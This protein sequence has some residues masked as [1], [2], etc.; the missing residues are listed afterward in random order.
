VDNRHTLLREKLSEDFLLIPIILSD[1]SGI[2]TL[3]VCKKEKPA[4]TSESGLLKV[5]HSEGKVREN[6][7][8]K[9]LTLW[10]GGGM[11]PIYGA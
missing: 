5:V 7:S 10:G 6:G 1:I 8:R 9:G 4:Y 2:P 11:V 3:I